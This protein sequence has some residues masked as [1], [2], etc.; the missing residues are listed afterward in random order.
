[1]FLELARRHGDYAIVGLAA[2]AAN[3]TKR[4]AF[5]GTGDRAI[6]AR[7]AAGAKDLES[8][9]AALAKD[10]QP[11]ADLYHSSQTKLHLARVLLERAW[12]KL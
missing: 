12:T 9:K 10:L 5:F 1:V 2:F 7:N 8:A 6:L 11:S 4:L 3:G